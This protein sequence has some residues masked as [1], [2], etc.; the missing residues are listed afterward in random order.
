MTAALTVDY[1]DT[2]PGNA[3]LTEQDLPEELLFKE[4]YADT[5]KVQCCNNIDSFYEYE[6]ILFWG[7]IGTSDFILDVI[8]E[9]YKIPL[10][11]ES[12]S[13]FLKNNKS[14]YAHTIFVENAI[15]EL[16]SGGLVR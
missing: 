4:A 16:I 6:N 5:F 10:L 7:K 12:K 1:S 13:V 9:G 14:A 8:Y 15:L 11:H 3:D 2:G